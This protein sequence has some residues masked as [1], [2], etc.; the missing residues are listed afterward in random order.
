MAVAQVHAAESK[1]T[2]A[3]RMAVAAAKKLL[4]AR[5][6]VAESASEIAQSN[7]EIAAA[8][9]D[10]AK[11]Y[12][13][14]DVARI[15][16][17]A[18]SAAAAAGRT[19]AGY[20]SLFAQSDGVVSERTVS[21]GTAVMPGQVIVRIKAVDTVRVQADLPQSF[22]GV[23]RAG[24]PVTVLA[25]D[26]AI[27]ATIH[28]VFPIVD[29]NSRTFK[30][31][32]LLPNHDRVFAVG[33]YA[34]LRVETSSTKESLCVRSSAV[35]TDA[36]GSRY[37]WVLEER[38]GGGQATD[39]TCTMHPEVSE[40]GPGKC[41]ICGMDLTPRERSGKYIA[42]KR[43]VEVG[44]G[45]GEYLTVASGLKEGDKVIWAGLDNLQ[46]GMAVEPKGGTGDEGR[47]TRQ[48]EGRSGG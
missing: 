32:A 18:F 4:A 38:A 47:G 43:K 8:A 28:S 11:S 48:V 1:A 42:S 37:V 36:D 22:L 39:W 20:R 13:E 25:G 35:L 5:Q 29:E 10:L 23:V 17:S 46:P 2:A 41:P 31:E 19:T 16:A 3:D 40:K 34:K 12:H 27:G 14:Q 33:M 6:M 9:A 15:E 30:V 26:K 45:D 24:T 7:A 44:P 21:P